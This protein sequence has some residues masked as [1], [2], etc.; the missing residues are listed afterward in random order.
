MRISSRKNLAPA[1][2]LSL[3]ILAVAVA[4][5][6]YAYRQ[7]LR[8]AYSR[9]QQ[10]PIPTELSRED[11]LAL[12]PIEKDEKPVLSV[13]P[14]KMPT[15]VFADE[16]AV[17]EPTEEASTPAPQPAPEPAPK[18]VVLPK[19]IPSQM[20]LKVPFVLQAPFK[21]WDEI[22]EDACEEASMLMLQAYENGESGPFTPEEMDR[23]I[24]RVVDY[25]V[26]TYGDYRNSDA[27]LTASVMRD[28]LGLEGTKVLPIGSADDI[29]R[30][31]AAGRPVIIPA[32][33]KL[34]M[35][36]NFRHG[37]PTY[38]MLV[39]KGYRADGSFVSNDPGTRLGEN[40]VYS[41]ATIMAAAHDWNGGDVEN[42]AQLM[43]V[44]TE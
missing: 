7:D 11:A 4:G 44:V 14:P 28:L 21:I 40:Y 36:P 24:M 43:I 23:R 32:A 16:P 41:E 22:H 39:L 30:Q 15:P 29:R 9:Y 17:A 5:G 25:L 10:G 27:E 3:M 8:D 6:A 33:G 35:N 38:H 19:D 2:K 1:L 12:Q 18:P 37:G 34:L 31:I 13:L 42:G 26:A 20:N